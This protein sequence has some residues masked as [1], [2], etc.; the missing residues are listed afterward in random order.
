MTGTGS[1]PNICTTHLCVPRGLTIR[2]G[3]EFCEMQTGVGTAGN[4]EQFSGA[5][6]K[7]EKE[8]CATES[9]GGAR[10]WEGHREPLKL[11]SELSGE[12]P[13][14]HEGWPGFFIAPPPKALEQRFST[15]GS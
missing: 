12:P 13:E 7:P 1:G 5:L 10:P 14:K 3:N 15:S 8:A 9:T 4:Q 2:R 6:E 11:A